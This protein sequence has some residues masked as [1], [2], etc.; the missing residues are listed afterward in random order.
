T[1]ARRFR[2]FAPLRWKPTWAALSPVRCAPGR[3]PAAPRRPRPPSGPR[4]RFRP[5]SNPSCRSSR[6]MPEQASWRRGPNP[7]FP[8]RGARPDP[9]VSAEELEPFPGESAPSHDGGPAEAELPAQ[10]AGTGEAV[11]AIFEQTRDEPQRSSFGPLLIL[12]AIGLVMFVGG[13][14]WT[15]VS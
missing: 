8:P 2:A 3:P 5:G 4:R 11:R 12:G 10:P 1:W 9:E 14:Y 13:L 15:Y 6:P 7:E